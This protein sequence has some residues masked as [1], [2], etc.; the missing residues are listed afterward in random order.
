MPKY[1]IFVLGTTGT[2]LFCGFYDGIEATSTAMDRI[3]V[4]NAISQA[5]AVLEN[6]GNN[7]DYSLVLEKLGALV[8]ETSKDEQFRVSLARDFSLLDVL[9]DVVTNSLLLDLTDTET[10]VLYVRVLRGVLI[11]LRNLVAFTEVFIDISMLLLNVQH[12]LSKVERSNPYFSRCLCVYFEI[13]ANISLSR[14]QSFQCNLQLVSQTIEPVLETTMQ[15]EALKQPFM[16]F[17][18]AALSDDDNVTSLLRDHCNKR[19]LGSLLIEGYSLLNGHENI[20][21]HTI[22]IFQRMVSNKRFKIWIESRENSIEFTSILEVARL[23]A[24]TEMEWDNTQCIIILEWV[25]FFFQ[26]WTRIAIDSLYAESEDARIAD[27]HP[28]LIIVLD[29]ISDLMK[30]HQAIQFLKHNFALEPLIGLLRAANDNGE[31][32]TV[33]VPIPQAIPAVGKKHFPMVKSLIVEIMAFLVHNS[34]EN[35]EKVRELHGLELLLSNCI[36]DDN[37]PYIKERA[38]LCLKFVLRNNPKN[39]EFV[40]Q[41]EAK[42]VVDDNALKEAGYEVNMEDGKVKLKRVGN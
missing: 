36:I 33:K 28:K 1:C 42:Q 4:D 7:M 34:F 15:V 11:V 22:S 18:N 17:L 31:I 27:I 23:V 21:E 13:L 12:F 16:T 41:L 10:S 32:S 39:Q 14:D 26:K 2:A 35:Q 6:G 9:V 38:I 3:E 8:S 29:I 40:A 25:Y 20:N 37:N 5:R 30:Y 19:L 24:T